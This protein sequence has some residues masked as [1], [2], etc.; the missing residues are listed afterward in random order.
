[1]KFKRFLSIVLAVITVA[2]CAVVIG[3]AVASGADVDVTAT[4]VSAYED[5]KSKIT[6]D[7]N[8]GLSSTV[9]DG[10]I[11][12]AWNWSFANIEANL[13]RVAAQGFTTIQ[14]SPPNEIKAGT[15][16]VHVLESSGSNGWWMYY[17]P[18]GFQ[19]NESTNNALGTKAEFVSMCTKAHELGLKVIVDAVI[20]HMG[21]CDNEDK[22]TST[23]PMAHLTPLAKTYEPEIYNAQ[24]FH[25][26]WANMTYKEDASR[27]SQYEST[28]DL[29]RNCTSRLPD[30]D[31]GSTVVQTAIYEYMA[32]LIESGADGFRF[33]A[34]KHIET[35]DDISSLAS[36]FWTNT[37]QKVRSTYK[38][39]EVYAYGEILNTCG[40]NRPYSMYTK[41]FDVTDSASYWDISNAVKG[42]GGNAT[43]Y[44]PSS[45]FTAANTI[46]WDESHDTYI[47]GSTTSTTV[48]QRNKIWALA[49]G[50]SGITTV[51]FARPDDG[52]NTNACYN[53][54]LGDVK[55]TSWSNEITKAIN[56]FHNYFI[57]SNEY[58][59][60]NSGG[61]AYIE[62]GNTGCMIVC[63]GGTT[64]KS[65]SLQNHQLTPGTYIDAITG[66]KFTVTSSRITG[67]VGTSGVAC[68]YFDNS[69]TPTTPTSDSSVSDDV[70]PTKDG[71]Y[72]IL[73][74]N[75]VP[76]SGTIY[77]YFWNSDGE[78]ASWPG[79]AM[80]YY[81]KNEYEQLRYIYFVPTSYDNYIISN[82]STQTV[83]IPL[84]GHTGVYADYANSEGKYEVGFWEIPVD[85]P[86][87]PVVNTDPPTTPASEVV[88]TPEDPTSST[89]TSSDGFTYKI[90]DADL[91][92]KIE[93]VDA[94]RIQRHLA[95]LDLLTDNQ[96]TAADTDEDGSVTIT[97][98]TYIQRYIAL[99]ATPTRCGE[100]V[101][102]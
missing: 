1:M 63:L 97:D 87:T 55:Y 17:Q 38:D 100:T 77:I 43:P 12:Q 45:N 22:I 93:V 53:I 21:T 48:A 80:T 30:L 83:D 78:Y 39:N 44:Y 67:Q 95:A 59:T 99:L 60:A 41:L 32:E 90:G 26:P 49:A 50:R 5:M 19:L 101:T 52:T 35:P 58:C 75:S 64:S 16:G 61:V 70:V 28:Y 88:T 24:A 66:N 34:A 14:V 92:G 96:L 81:D 27:Y 42:Y 29:T 40:V 2:S 25:K 57:G 18:A 46:L 54:L 6:A 7:N 20:N 15:S 84:T 4:G 56:Q 36:N 73:F 74:S 33:D 69:D 89:P 86:T 72:T 37:L 98:V 3:T 62:R 71:C 10:T 47:D 102:K 65:V 8:Y 85:L 13:E 82:G 91:N 79:T 94:T 23:D 68:L 11:L 76:F 51:Y 31:T 9:D